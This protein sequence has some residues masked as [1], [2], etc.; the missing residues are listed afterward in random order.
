MNVVNYDEL[1][2]L[3]HGEMYWL[4]SSWKICDGNL[5]KMNFRNMKIHSKLKESLQKMMIFFTDIKNAC[6]FTWSLFLLNCTKSK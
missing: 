4:L 6:L 3:Y 5:A 1:D 2:L